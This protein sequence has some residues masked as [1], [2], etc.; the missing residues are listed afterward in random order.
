M[1]HIGKKPEAATLDYLG[2]Q[3]VGTAYWNLHPAELT[4]ETLTLGQGEF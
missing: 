2:L 3:H 4:E 1:T